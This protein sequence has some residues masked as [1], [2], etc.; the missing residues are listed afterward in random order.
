[1]KR[2]PRVLLIS[3]AYTHPQDQGN[4]ARVHAFGRELQ[5]RGI[6]VELLYFVLAGLTDDGLYQ[7][8]QQW[9]AVH[10]VP[11]IP[12]KPQSHAAHWGLDDWCPD[13][14]LAKVRALSLTQRYDAVVVNY[15]WLS[16]CFEAVDESLRIL[17]TH[18]LFGDRA[19]IARRAGLEP[20]WF[21][22]T[23]DEEA[24]GLNRAD[25]V[26]AIQDQEERI[27][28][29]RTHATVMTAGHV[30]DDVPALQRTDNSRPLFGYFGSGNPWN[31]ASIRTLDDALH[32]SPE[33][34]D[35]AI[36]GSVCDRVPDLRTSPVR[37]GRVHEPC[38]FYD[39]VDCVLNPMTAGT[40]LKIKTI[41]A[42][43]YGRPV[44][45]TDQAFIGLPAVHDA[46]RLQSADDM[47]ASM[48]AFMRQRLYRD[49]LT[50]ASR[51]LW[52]EYRS[53]TRTQYD[54]LANAIRAST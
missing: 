37:L 51:R 28:R 4:A 13:S 16:R 2:T 5:R 53:I 39:A 19:T 10:L 45:G 20:S 46:H 54:A 15:V 12:H 18:D 35:W 33:P 47:A 40:G 34:L 48:R 9:D 32:Q 1:M 3:P 7:M 14:L 17:D 27:L 25:L 49:E 42:L 43:A 6:A 29:Q 11:K 41:E 21:F 23:I 22:T 52:G 44:I 8:Q 26:I 36:A 50:L 38:D 31:V 30:V 24:R